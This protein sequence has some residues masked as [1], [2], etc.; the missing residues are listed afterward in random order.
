M[1]TLIKETLEKVGQ[2]VTLNGW[3]DSIR[4]HGKVAFIDLRDRSGKIQCVG[5]DLPKVTAESVVEINGIVA[6]RPEKLINPKLP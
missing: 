2:S 6:K 5:K 3:V 1:R 4:D